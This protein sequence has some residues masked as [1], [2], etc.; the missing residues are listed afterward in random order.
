MPLVKLSKLLKDAE[1]GG[2]AIGYFESWDT[3]SFEAVLEA[4]EEANSPVVL[5]IGG[6][7]MDQNWLKRF[8]ISPL[9]AYGRAMAEQAG[10][11]AAFIL[12]EVKLLEHVHKG[13]LSGYNCVMLDSCHLPFDENVSATRQVVGLA[14]PLGIEVQAEFGRLPTFGEEAKGTLTDPKQASLFVSQTDVDFLA[15][16]IGNVHLQTEGSTSL[17]IDRLKAIRKMVDVPLVIHGGTGFPP[18]KIREVIQIGASLFHF[19]TSMKKAFYDK[20]ATVFNSIGNGK[21]DYQALVGSRKES[22]VLMPAKSEI[23]R[24]VK[25]MISLYGSTN[26]A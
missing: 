4:A 26:K 5:G 15:V 14:K 18:E 23:K 11:P 6:T 25:E 2:Y 10:V 9:G 16:S 17:D 13:V 20:T 8:G 19:G 1:A 3:Y 21:K 24:I 12:N 22:D 7:M